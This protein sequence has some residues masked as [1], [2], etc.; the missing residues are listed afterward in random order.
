MAD[1][2]H[3]GEQEARFAMHLTSRGELMGD[4][5]APAGETSNLIDASL[6]N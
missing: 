1:L 5:Y 2:L 6:H 3:D 4:T